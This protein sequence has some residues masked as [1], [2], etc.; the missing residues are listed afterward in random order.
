[1]VFPRDSN[2]VSLGSNEV[3]NRK[4]F[5]TQRIGILKL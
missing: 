3:K 4:L 1:M 2:E 5:I